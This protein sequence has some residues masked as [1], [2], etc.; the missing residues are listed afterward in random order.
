MYIQT[1]GG[2][3]ILIGRK[4]RGHTPSH[5]NVDAVMEGASQSISLENAQ[6]LK[7]R[8]THKELKKHSKSRMRDQQPLFFGGAFINRCE[9]GNRYP[10]PPLW[11]VCG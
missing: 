9:T 3:F 5:H 6:I 10:L 2:L 7:S 11:G 4:A 8:L 1:V